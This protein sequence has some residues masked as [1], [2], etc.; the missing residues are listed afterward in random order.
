MRLFDPIRNGFKRQKIRRL[1]NA[2][3]MTESRKE[4][5]EELSRD[6]PNKSMAQ[7]IVIRSLYNQGKWDELLTFVELNPGSRFGKLRK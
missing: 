4:A 1:Y 7:D 6:T 5:M 2:G 3:K